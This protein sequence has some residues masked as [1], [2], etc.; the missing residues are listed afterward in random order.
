MDTPEEKIPCCSSCAFCWAISRYLIDATKKTKG[1]VVSE[2]INTDDFT[3]GGSIAGYRHDAR[4]K[5]VALNYCPFCGFDF[6]PLL[7]SG[8]YVGA[9]KEL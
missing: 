7:R 4:G 6:Q 8:E 1:L 9:G 3:S 2:F 5:V